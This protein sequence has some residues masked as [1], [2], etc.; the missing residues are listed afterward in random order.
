MAKGRQREGRRGKNLKTLLIK[1]CKDCCFL[2]SFI[3]KNKKKP[4]CISARG[5]AFEE[6]QNIY[7]IPKWCPNL[8]KQMKWRR[9]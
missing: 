8:E 6:N 2:D 3:D 5:M 4:F 7:T 1:A 9:Q